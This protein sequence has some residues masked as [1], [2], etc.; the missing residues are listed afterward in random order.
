MS[1]STQCFVGMTS[2][3]LRRL[4]VELYETHRM[5]LASAPQIAKDLERQ[6]NDVA[7]WLCDR[8]TGDESIKPVMLLGAVAVAI[9]WWTHRSRPAPAHAL[10]Q[11]IDGVAAGESYLLPIPRCDPCF[12]GSA[13]KFKWCHGRPPN[14]VPLMTA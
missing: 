4:Q 11:A 7:T 2:D 6:A 3:E 10:Q 14:A 1:D 12:C 9:A 8:E 5:G 13:T